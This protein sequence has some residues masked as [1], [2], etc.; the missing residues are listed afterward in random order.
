[1]YDNC[2]ANVAIKNGKLDAYGQFYILLCNWGLSQGINTGISAGVRVCVPLLA[3]AILDTYIRLCADCRRNDNIPYTLI[4]L[5][6]VE[7]PRCKIFILRT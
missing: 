2:I 5:D 1:M 6:V 3:C 4:L 7:R